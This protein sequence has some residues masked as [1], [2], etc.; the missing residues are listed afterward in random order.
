[1]LLQVA[2]CDDSDCPSLVSVRFSLPPSLSLSPSLSLW[3]ILAELSPRR[4]SVRRERFLDIRRL[5]E[6]REERMENI[7]SLE[8]MV[9]HSCK[10]PDDE[11]NIPQGIVRFDYS[12]QKQN[13]FI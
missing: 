1:M 11:E 8:L 3:E 7:S 5:G 13:I 6:R 9:H 2:R 12:P 10:I 4:N